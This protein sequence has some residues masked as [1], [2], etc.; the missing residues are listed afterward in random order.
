[1]GPADSGAVTLPPT[2]ITIAAGT[3]DGGIASYKMELLLRPHGPAEHESALDDNE[4]GV[5]LSNKLQII[6][7]SP[8]HKGSVR[9]L[10][11][12]IS[13]T[14]K[15]SGLLLSTGYDEMLH[16]VR[17]GADS[18]FR[19]EG[20]VRTPADFG[21]PCCSA[22]A[23]PYSYTGIGG[24]NT[25]GASTH[26]LVGFGAAAWSSE[27]GTTVSSTGGK[28]VIY[29]KRDWSVQ[30][31]LAGHDGGVASLSV[32]PTGKL[33]LSGGQQ[34]GKIKLWDLER[35]RLA[36]SSPTI[37]KSTGSSAAGQSKS[38]YDSIDCIVWNNSHGGD[39]YAFCHGSHI[40][41]RDVQTG[42]DMLDVD[43]P[44]KV[45]QICLLQGAEGLFVAAACN[46]GSL[47]LLAVS[48]PSKNDRSDARLFQE[49]ERPAIMAIEPVEGPVAGQERF[50]CI[51]AVCGYHIVTAN[52]AGV[53][54]V[55]NLQGAVNMLTSPDAEAAHV[56]DDEVSEDD[57]EAEDSDAKEIETELAVDIIDSVQLG[58]GARITCLTAW[59][60]AADQATSQIQVDAGSQQMT[61]VP[62]ER[63]A[64]KSVRKDSR[65]TQQVVLDP[66]SL[67]RA[68]NLVSVAKKIQ[69]RKSEKKHKLTSQRIK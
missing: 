39:C 19:S 9:S 55:M 50:K 22:F 48:I 40:T 2:L 44:S 24:A 65:I 69:K 52:S 42:K 60:S 43:L 23:P 12:A 37:R 15:R 45:N 30:H 36:F 49:N 16:A 53:V 56:A 64:G 66:E 21:T 34:D 28:L 41:V 63:E 32:H 29:K 18:V 68:R 27:D 26:C 7:A 14:V 38:F 3:Y 31:V 51:Q 33:A 47:P 4:T 11:V 58:S 8:V 17:F 1:M 62:A 57:S 59:V 13:P 67:E 20:E 54:S 25:A 35:G 10:T 46:D 6:F 5:V 61:S